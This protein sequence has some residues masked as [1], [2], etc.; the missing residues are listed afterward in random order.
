MKNNVQ[1][2]SKNWMVNKMAKIATRE[3]YGKALMKIAQNNPNVVVLDADLSGSTKSGSIKKV[4]PE[5]FFNMGIAEANM[6][7]VAAG[8]AASGKIAFASSFA[9]F[10]T[11]RA[12]EQIRNSI[13]YPALNVK[14]CA[15]H[16]GISVGEDGASHQCIEDLALMR[17]IPT[18]TVLQPADAIECEQMI[19]KVVEIEGPC[20]VRTS[21][22]ATDQV[23]DENYKFE[24]GKADVIQE[25]HDVLIIATGLE[26]LD[27]IK[28]A[29]LLKEEG[30]EPTILNIHTIKPLDEKTIVEMAKTHS[31][32]IT[33]E[34]HSVIGGLGSAVADALVRN[35]PA[36]VTM[37]GVQDK[38]GESGKPVQLFDKYELDAKH[39]ADKVKEL[40]HGNH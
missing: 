8:L 26:V 1:K 34:E 24:F 13:G 18:M 29:E 28:A 14:V 10:A 30:I 9:M 16:A 11:G 3:A 12:Y 17:V 2:H 25:G 4:R 19:E 23:H 36:K 33:V 7:S 38:F 31:T 32:I 6:M 21:R 35:Y 15:S 40:V 39:I 37:M 22:L 20:Y 27:A 5:N